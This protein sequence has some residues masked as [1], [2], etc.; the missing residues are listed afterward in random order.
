M[1]LLFLTG[2]LRSGALSVSSL[3]AGHFLFLVLDFPLWISQDG[4]G[5]FTG[6]YTKKMLLCTKLMGG[7]KCGNSPHSSLILFQLFVFFLVFHVMSLMLLMRELRWV[8]EPG[9]LHRLLFAFAP[10]RP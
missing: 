9:S 5:H 10:L 3:W 4:T 2:E 6:C 1:P 8:G 7:L